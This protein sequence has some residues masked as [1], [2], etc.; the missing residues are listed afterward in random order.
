MGSSSAM[1]SST[2]LSGRPTSPTPSLQSINSREQGQSSPGVLVVVVSD[3]CW[4][5]FASPK[6]MALS[7][8]FPAHPKP[9]KTNLKMRNAASNLPDELDRA[10]SRALRM[11]RMASSRSCVTVM[12]AGKLSQKSQ[13][14]ILSIPTSITWKASYPTPKLRGV[15]VIR[16]LLCPKMGKTKKLEIGMLRRAGK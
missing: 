13:V 1:A 15:V 7:S 4:A 3:H 11:R 16:R 9:P 6:A 2:T 5:K 10:V 14:C 12:V 8:I